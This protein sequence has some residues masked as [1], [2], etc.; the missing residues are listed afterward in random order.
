M[1]SKNY[2]C[3]S[4]LPKNPSVLAHK[5]KNKPLFQVLIANTYSHLKC[6]FLIWAKIHSHNSLT[7]SIITFV[8][9]LFIDGFSPMKAET[10]MNIAPNTWQVCYNSLRMNERYL[11]THYS[12]YYYWLRTHYLYST[13]LGITE[14]IKIRY[15]LSLSKNMVPSLFVTVDPF[16][17]SDEDMVSL[18]RKII[19]RLRFW[20]KF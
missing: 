3:S 19:T 17:I 11:S 10:P 14:S 7:L 5:G 12:F 13:L 4:I 1:K 2:N 6:N 16:W 18:S 8:S 9:S 20:I 15:K